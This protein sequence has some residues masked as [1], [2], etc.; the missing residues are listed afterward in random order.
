MCFPL[1]PAVLSLEGEDYFTHE[2]GGFTDL[3]E[4]EVPAL[5][6]SGSYSTPL[7][8]NKTIA[9]VEKQDVA[10]PLFVYLAFQSVHSPL[11]GA[12]RTMD[13]VTAP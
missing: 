8:A 9:V 2:A 4:N 13:S 1:L 5:N 3:H 12:R 7:F 10:I 11:H 6:Y